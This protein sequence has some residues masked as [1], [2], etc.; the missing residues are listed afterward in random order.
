MKNYPIKSVL[1]LFL[2]VLTG[3]SNLNL[4]P[5]D[6]PSYVST[7]AEIYQ[8]NLESIS[9]VRKGECPMHPSCSSFS[10]QAFG[11]HGFFGGTILTTDRLIRCGR[12]NKKRMKIINTGRGLKFYD[13]VPEKILEVKNE[14]N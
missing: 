8:K 12:E 4:N 10:K 5:E 7:M 9:F 2:F 6:D 14:K 11:K 13:P 3:C 1:F